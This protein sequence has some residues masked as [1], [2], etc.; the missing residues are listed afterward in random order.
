M[1]AI[2]TERYIRN[3]QMLRLLKCDL[4]LGYTVSDRDEHVVTREE[5]RKYAYDQ[6]R[7]LDSILFPEYGGQEDHRF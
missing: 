5:Q 6:S 2:A 1:H 7:P 3:S 4:L